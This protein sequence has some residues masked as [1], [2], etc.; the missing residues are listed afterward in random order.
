[1]DP[2]FSLLPLMLAT[3]ESHEIPQDIVVQVE[4]GEQSVTCNSQISRKSKTSRQRSSNFKR[5]KYV[6]ASNQP[7]VREKLVKTD[8]MKF[9]D[10]GSK[11]FD[12]SKK[13]TKFD[14]KSDNN[15]A[16]VG[17]K[18]VKDNYTKL[19]SNKLDQPNKAD[20]K[21]E[22]VKQGDE[23]DNANDG[24]DLD[25]TERHISGRSEDSETQDNISMTA[26]TENDVSEMPENEIED[27]QNP[28]RNAVEVDKTD[29]RSES[30]EGN[31]CY[32]LNHSNNV[33]EE[34]AE[35][36]D[37]YTSDD[38]KIAKTDSDTEKDKHEHASKKN[39]VNQS[40][41]THNQVEKFISKDE[42]NKDD[43][44]EHMS[45]AEKIQMCEAILSN[46]MK[47]AKGEVNSNEGSELD[48]EEEIQ[49]ESE[50]SDTLEE[51]LDE[52]IDDQERDNGSLNGDGTV[53]KLMI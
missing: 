51:L 1:M 3:E 13:T 12:E 4:D 32:Q 48:I 5:D 44:D 38:T 15:S 53:V 36:I 6:H 27:E 7:S 52:Y 23:E 16:K 34:I 2:P 26:R 35:E 47:A 28:E 45:E 25:Q 40:V 39:F 33:E 31:D 42:N 9:K 49:E 43:A 17:K 41:D 20:I 22:I 18:N 50:D 24:L 37:G 46:Y 21:D 10:D 8:R 30:L 19:H 14:N 11:A 29:N